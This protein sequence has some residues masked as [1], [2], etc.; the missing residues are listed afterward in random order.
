M[1][2]FLDRYTDCSDIFIAYLDGTAICGHVNLRQT[3]TSD[4]PGCC[5]LRANGLTTPKRHA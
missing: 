5:T 1:L 4:A 2:V 3:M